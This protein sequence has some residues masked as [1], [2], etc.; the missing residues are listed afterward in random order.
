MLS[1]KACQSQHGLTTTLPAAE[2]PGYSPG[3]LP[4]NLTLCSMFGSD[5][6][7]TGIIVP[8]NTTTVM[9]YD[10]LPSLGASYTQPTMAAALVTYNGANQTLRRDE[11]VFTMS[12][13]RWQISCLVMSHF[14]LSWLM[15]DIIPGQ[16]RVLLKT[17]VW[18]RGHRFQQQGLADLVS[19]GATTKDLHDCMYKHD[20]FQT[21]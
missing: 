8:C 9:T 21:C 5:F 3:T 17:Q 18:G 11:M 15:H 1:N 12:C 6:A 14:S 10:P 13:A 20:I 19:I 7:T 4:G 2:L 16:R